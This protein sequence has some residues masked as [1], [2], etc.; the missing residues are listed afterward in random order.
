MDPVARAN[1]RSIEY[2]ERHLQRVSLR[3]SKRDQHRP[4]S[5]PLLYDFLDTTF[6]VRKIQSIHASGGQAPSQFPLISLEKA[7]YGGQS[8]FYVPGVK[9]RTRM[10]RIRYLMPYN[11][12][13]S[14]SIRGVSRAI[15][16][17]VFEPESSNYSRMLDVFSYEIHMSRDLRQKGLL[18]IQEVQ[19]IIYYGKEK[20]MQ[21]ALLVNVGNQGS[22]VQFLEK[23]STI[24]SRIAIGYELLK[25]LEKMHETGVGH[26][27]LCEESLFV[28]KQ[29][30]RPPNLIVSGL[31]S[32]SDVSSCPAELAPLYPS[33]EMVYHRTGRGT[34]PI[35]LASDLWNVGHILF[36]LKNKT[37][38]LKTYHLELPSELFFHKLAQMRAWC[39][40]NLSISEDPI[41]RLIDSCL[42]E[43]PERR[44]SITEAKQ[45]VEK[46]LVEFHQRNASSIPVIFKRERSFSLPQIDP[47]LAMDPRP[48]FPLP[49]HLKEYVWSETDRKA[50]LQTALEIATVIANMHARGI[51]HGDL[52]DNTITVLRGLE[53]GSIRIA[54]SSLSHKTPG[55][56]PRSPVDPLGEFPAPE[57]VG[58]R[59]SG[60]SILPTPAN[61]LWDL[62]ALIDMLKGRGL[63][64]L[65]SSELNSRMAQDGVFFSRSLI[66]MQGWVSHV[67][68]VSEDLV[69]LLVARLLSVN[70]ADRPS[71]SEVCCV[72][73]ESL[74]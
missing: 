6:S 40:T 43:N 51:V 71:A 39:H 44:P 33:P 9:T 13:G 31:R 42:A 10:K 62:G 69:D 64:C 72:L 47:Q 48:V 28:D 65:R 37:S 15:F 1:S 8:D 49:V 66:V 60:R 46:W 29:E 53:S 56:N 3:Q 67:L 11:T 45:V 17:I 54:E 32:L 34:S 5:P 35:G 38:L 22:L 4:I 16:K 25:T 19:P 20:P 68:K 26:F 7:L 24:E 50:R 52:S 41:D 23:E 2:C 12:Q 36:L 27:G 57:L 21:S 74:R 61:D 55:L 58:A 59:L 70:P 14:P 30:G 18:D 73:Q 63:F